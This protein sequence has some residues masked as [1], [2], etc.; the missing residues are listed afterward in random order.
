M[1]NNVKLIQIE[2]DKPR[3]LR[4]DF[5]AYAAFEGVTGKNMFDL[6]PRLTATD[7][8]ALL[9]ALL[10]HEDK[11]LTIEQVGAMLTPDNLAAVQGALSA[12]RA[13][14]EPPVAAAAPAAEGE[15]PPP[16]ASL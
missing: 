10:L 11:T 6:P 4:Y 5:N 3:A 15:P 12:A 1:G 16:A 8:R 7:L 13:A 14:N 9:W 2:L